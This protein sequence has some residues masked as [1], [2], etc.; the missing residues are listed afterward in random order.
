MRLDFTHDVK[1]IGRVTKITI[2]KEKFQASLSRIYK[3]DHVNNGRKENA[4]AVI[5]DLIAYEHS[6]NIILSI[7][8]LIYLVSISVKMVDTGGV[9]SGGSS[10]NTMNFVTFGKEKLSQVRTILTGDTSNQCTFNLKLGVKME[11]LLGNDFNTVLE[12][13]FTPFMVLVRG[14]IAILGL[15]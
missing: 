8:K 2:V 11:N 3:Y 14:L 9:E 4:I 12:W 7:R 6:V 15:R 5:L 10:N 13:Y 1:K